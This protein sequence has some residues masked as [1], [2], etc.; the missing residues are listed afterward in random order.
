MHGAGQPPFAHEAVKAKLRLAAIRSLRRYLTENGATL[1]NTLHSE[2]QI[3]VHVAPGI[4]VDGRID[5]IKKLDTGTTSIVDFKSSERAQAEDITR[6]QLHIYAVGYQELTGKR[7][8]LL[9]VL[10]LD[11][12]AQSKREAVNDGLLTGI[13]DK[14]AAAGEDLRANRLARL[15]H[16]CGTC[17]SCDLAGLCRNRPR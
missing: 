17:D 4:T 9:E 11:D 13:R 3:Q 10:N 2:Q 8:D 12:R 15:P 7:A 5:L 6:D 16:W 14:I 1:S